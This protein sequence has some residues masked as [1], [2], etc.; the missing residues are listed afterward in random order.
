[1]DLPEGHTRSFIVRCRADGSP[2][3]EE[4]EG[5]LCQ[6]IDVPSGERRY[7]SDLDRL[8][9]FLAPRLRE[10]GVR[11]TL[12]W[13]LRLWLQTARSRVRLPWRD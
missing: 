11:L 7:F 3:E 9:D 12:Y 4:R 1:M 8:V 2:P 5:W 10:A 6:V 13:R